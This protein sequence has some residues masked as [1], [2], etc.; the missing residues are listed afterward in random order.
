MEITVTAKLR[1]EYIPEI[2][3]STAVRK[4]LNSL[5]LS[6]NAILLFA[7]YRCQT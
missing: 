4:L 2:L 6:E 3:A 5:L 1:A 7:L